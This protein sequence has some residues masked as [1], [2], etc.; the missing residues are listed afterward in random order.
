VLLHGGEI[1]SS[2]LATNGVPVVFD[3]DQNL[4][5]ALPHRKQTM[6]DGGVVP[7]VP[8]SHHRA[9]AMGDGKVV[10]VG[11][12]KRTSTGA[13]VADPEIEWYDPEVADTFL[14]VGLSLPRLNPAAVAT[15]DGGVLAVFGGIDETGVVTN[16]IH[17]YSW[18]GT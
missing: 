3:L 17:Y 11:G 1:Y 16:E 14:A 15:Q 5:G 6:D 2:G 18:D 8:R 9:V 7:V 12:Y 10:F 13:L 4:Y